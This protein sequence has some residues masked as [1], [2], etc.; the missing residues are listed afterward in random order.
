MSVKWPEDNP[1]EYFDSLPGSPLEISRNRAKSREQRRDYFRQTAESL[2]ADTPLPALLRIELG[3]MFSELARVSTEGLA[4][5]EAATDKRAA[6]KRDTDNLHAV[7][8]EHLGLS[9]GHAGRKVSADEV[10]RVIEGLAEPGA[11]IYR[12]K[13]TGE[14]VTTPAVSSLGKRKKIAEDIFGVT[15]PVIAARWKEYMQPAAVAERVAQTGAT[16]AAIEVLV[17]NNKSR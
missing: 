16:L 8:T 3:Q 6:Q 14:V 9:A 12:A 17:E 15:R 4:E 7:L 1:K 13:E 2:A 5:I 10:G 11:H